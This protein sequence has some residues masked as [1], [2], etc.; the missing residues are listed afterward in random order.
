MVYA[1][2][3]SSRVVIL[4]PVFFVHKPKFFK[5]LKNLKTFLQKPTFF[6]GLGWLPS[7][8]YQL[9][10]ATLTSLPYL[11]RS[12]DPEIP[13]LGLGITLRVCVVRCGGFSGK[14]TCRLI[15]EGEMMDYHFETVQRQSPV[16]Y[17][18]VCLVSYYPCSR[19]RRSVVVSAL[20]SI[21]VVNRH[22]AR[23]LL[24]WVTACGQVKHLDV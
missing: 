5:N 3:C 16:Y 10:T 15:E 21:N 9:R 22:W 11:Y 20:A 24:G 8:R 4:C 18:P 6:P 14:T 23:L 19:W 17:R 2:G 12:C 13:T 1:M 7:D